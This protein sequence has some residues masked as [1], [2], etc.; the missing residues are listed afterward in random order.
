MGGNGD[1]HEASLPK[2]DLSGTVMYGYIHPEI[3][4]PQCRYINMAYGPMAY[5]AWSV[6]VGKGSMSMAGTVVH[7]FAKGVGADAAALC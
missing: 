2:H 7:D 6:W 4:P 3:Q 5:I 1:G